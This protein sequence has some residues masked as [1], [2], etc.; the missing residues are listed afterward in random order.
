M[1][2]RPAKPM[3]DDAPSIIDLIVRLHALW[4]AAKG[5]LNYVKK[6][7]VRPG[8]EA[9]ASGRKH[10]VWLYTFTVDGRRRC[11]YVAPEYVADLQQALANGAQIERLL[12][13]CGEIVARHGATE[14]GANG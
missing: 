4:P 9:C 5:S 12:Y 8:C 6:P 2:R 3:T 13:Q 14:K 10:P 7:C 1:V 11:V